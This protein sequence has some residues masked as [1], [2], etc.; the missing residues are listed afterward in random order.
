MLEETDV[1]SKAIQRKVRQFRAQPIRT[2]AFSDADKARTREVLTQFEHS[3]DD[4]DQVN[5]E[6]I[7]LGDGKYEKFASFMTNVRKLQKL[8]ECTHTVSQI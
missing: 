3:D 8:V 4:D 7:S 6:S 1:L 2:K 5:L